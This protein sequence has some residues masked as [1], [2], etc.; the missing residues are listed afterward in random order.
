VIPFVV[1][2]GGTIGSIFV[3][4]RALHTMVRVY[5]NILF[6]V[7]AAEIAMW[8]PSRAAAVP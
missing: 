3:L 2:I 5:G 4:K 1:L 6:I 8:L 7:Y